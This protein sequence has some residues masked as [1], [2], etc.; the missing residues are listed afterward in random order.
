MI[1]RFL[2]CMIAVLCC[3]SLFSACVTPVINY[4]EMDLNPKAQTKSAQTG[5]AQTGIAQTEQILNLIY[6]GDEE[7]VQ[8][9]ESLMKKGFLDTNSEEYG[10][11]YITFGNKFSNY[12]IGNFYNSIGDIDKILSGFDNLGLAAIIIV[13]VILVLYITPLA[14]SAV[15]CTLGA[16]SDYATFN[17]DAEL[18]IFDS[19]GNLIK[20]FK[21]NG[22]FKQ[23]AGFYYGHNPVKKASEA[24]LKLYDKMFQTANTDSVQI[25]KA[26]R[27]S[28]PITEENKTQALEKIRLYLDTF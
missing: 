8:Q 13:P 14:V 6:Y 11:F 20:K 21:E 15:L 26:L 7:I 12:H 9:G 17:I 24:F 25:N 22:S 18:H 2:N 27:F 19:E 3:I 1:K 23:A 10:Y 16:P 28:G 4:H 5:F